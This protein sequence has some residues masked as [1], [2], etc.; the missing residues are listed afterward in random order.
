M[1]YVY[2]ICD[3]RASDPPRALR[4]LGG[5]AVRTLEHDGLAALYTRHRQ[6]RVRPEP[7]LVLIHERVVE[8]GMAAGDILPL[9]F[10]TQLEDEDALATVLRERREKLLGALD[11]VRGRVEVG[12]RV[13]PMS[14]ERRIGA[15]S[16]RSGRE[17]L[18]ASLAEA[19]VLRRPRPPALLAGSYL[20]AADDAAEFRAHA[21]ALA[22]EHDEVRVLVTG[23]WPPYSFVA[24]G[25]DEN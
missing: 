10:G 15:A 17:Y 23:P 13:I 16:E 18:L 1:I 7:E 3:A 11:R 14:S 2:G 19:S 25:H 24:E 20:V 4:G 6:L 21:R 8:N 22:A 9:R 12:L 5:A